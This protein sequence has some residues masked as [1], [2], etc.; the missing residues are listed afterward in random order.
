M[1]LLFGPNSSIVTKGKFVNVKHFLVL[2]LLVHLSLQYFLYV[3][4]VRCKRHLTFSQAI[5]EKFPQRK[6]LNTILLLK[7]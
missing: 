6:Q 4:Q 7:T 1:A 2:N 5:R 3:K